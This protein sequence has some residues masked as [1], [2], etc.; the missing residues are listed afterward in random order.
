VH[1]NRYLLISA[2]GFKEDGSDRIGTNG[3]AFRPKKYVGD[4]F[5]GGAIAGVH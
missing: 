2:V 4:Q 3:A 1:P 5:R